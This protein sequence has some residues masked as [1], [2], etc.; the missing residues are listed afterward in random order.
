MKILCLLAGDKSVKS[1][2]IVNDIVQKI[3]DTELFVG[4]FPSDPWE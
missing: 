1:L 3:D 2:N 4:S